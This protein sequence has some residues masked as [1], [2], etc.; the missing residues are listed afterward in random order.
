[1]CSYCTEFATYKI[2]TLVVEVELKYLKKMSVRLKGK[3]IFPP[4]R[5][6]IFFRCLS[7]FPCSLSIQ[8]STSS[9]GPTKSWYPPVKRTWLFKLTAIPSFMAAGNFGPAVH[10]LAPGRRSSMESRY[11][12]VNPST[13][14]ATSRPWLWLERR[15][16]VSSFGLK[17]IET[18][19]ISILLFEACTGG[20]HPSPVQLWQL[21][22][23]VS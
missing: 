7:C 17:I 1:M 6:I 2:P 11:W 16:E 20:A 13:P 3:T 8:I 21:H 19:K 4:Q 9:T 18:H 10:S 5:K 22:F 14:P 12:P 23:K 15:S